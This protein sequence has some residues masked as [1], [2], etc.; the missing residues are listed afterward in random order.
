MHR[1]RVY[2]ASAKGEE[3]ARVENQGSHHVARTA[4]RVPPVGTELDGPRGSRKLV[5]LL[6]TA[7]GRSFRLAFVAMNCDRQATLER[8]HPQLTR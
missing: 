2:E 1:F 6:C 4:G 3:I 7:T 8:L 5:R